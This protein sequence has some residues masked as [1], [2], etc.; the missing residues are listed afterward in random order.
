[1]DYYIPQITGPIP[2]I[3]N[4]TGPISLIDNDYN[5]GWFGTSSNGQFLIINGGYAHIGTGGTDTGSGGGTSIGGTEE[6]KKDHKK[7]VIVRV[8]FATDRNFT[9]GS[10][11]LFG[12]QRSEISY[13]GY[14]DISIPPTHRIG[15]IETPSSW[16][17]WLLEFTE[18]PEQ[19]DVIPLLSGY[20]SNKFNWL[21]V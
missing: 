13:Y 5:G 16:L 9:R 18:D 20:N 14:C 21:Q 6:E 19:H 2:L 17:P 12:N 3:D 8:F 10:N 15:E 4:I 7:N 1:M 11:M